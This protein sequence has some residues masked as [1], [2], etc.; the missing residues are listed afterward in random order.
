VSLA[1][2]LAALGASVIPVWVYDHDE[3]RFRWANP[4]A[5]PLWRA[6]SLAE[7]LARDFSGNSASSR[8]RLD[9]YLHVLRGGGVVSEDWT[10]YPR[11]QPETMTL[12][13]SGVR[14]DDGRLAIL[15]QAVRK[16]EPVDPSMV[17]GVEAL[18]HT[19]LMV[20]LI[21]EDGAAIFHNPAAL[22]AFGDASAIGP[23]LS[24]AGADLLASVRRGEAFEAELPVRRVDGERW[25]SLRATP[26]VDPVT[27]ARAVLLQQLDI[28]K[29]RDAEDLAATRSR[30]VDQLGRAL[31]VVEQQ[32]QQILALS[33]PL[34][35]VGDQTLAVPL[36]G[37]LTRERVRE[38]CERLLPALHRGHRRHLILDLTGCEAL[39]ELGAR[40]LGE[41]I[42]AAA[43]LGARTVLTGIA[44]GLARA[45]IAAN[46]DLSRIQTLQTLRDGI[47]HCRAAQA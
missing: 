40:S 16:A 25:H 5:L 45:M 37:D 32:R 18:R 13:A 12:H 29:R 17:R 27:G 6:D 20:S 11:G 30:D 26:V 33:A 22:R 1:E 41:L 9:N 14:L 23:W 31:A 36:I 15:F 4:A 7:L 10:L 28:H 47:D 8:T 46:L 3:G 2:R 38:V 42:A 19:S 21:A 35:D 44:P 43:L 34:L 24:D 39:D